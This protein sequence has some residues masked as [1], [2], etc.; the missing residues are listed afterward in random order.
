MF[1]YIKPSI[2]EMR[3]KEYNFYKQVYCGLCREMKKISSIVPFTLSYDFVFLALCRMTAEKDSVTFKKCRCAARPF[4]KHPFVC[5]G[6]ALSYCANAS[7]LLTAE[8]FRDDSNDCKGFKRLISKHTCKRLCKMLDRSR[9]ELPYESV[10]MNL[11]KLSRAEESYS[12]SVYDGA[13]C[14]GELLGDIFCFGLS[15]DMKIPMYNI[16]NAIGRWIYI[17]DAFSDIKDDLKSGAYNPFVLSMAN[18]QS[19]EFRQNISDSLAFELSRITNDAEL[20]LKNAD[21]GIA[22][23][24]RNILFVG[25]PSI[26][27]DVIFKNRKIKDREDLPDE[28]SL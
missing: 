28:R 7:V 16:G 14:F 22:E 20:L 2:P 26:A 6:C 23:I 9:P 4:S 15:D 10:K 5:T 17:I 3:I 1:G 18:T 11:E 24:I 25:M 8:K 12:E 27:N 13:E 21:P 19:D